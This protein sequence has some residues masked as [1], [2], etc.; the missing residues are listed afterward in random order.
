MLTCKFFIT[1]WRKYKM[2]LNFSLD[3]L[4]LYLDDDI[5]L[6]AD[7]LINAQKLVSLTQVEKN[8]FIARF[9]EGGDAIETEV[10]FAGTKVKIAT[11][12]CAEFHEKEICRHIGAAL[13]TLLERRKARGEA[14]KAT[15]Q[16][17]AQNAEAPK[18]T[19]PNILK[20]IDAPQLIEFIAD[21]ARNDK[22]FALA[23]KTRF[24][25]DLSSGTVE[26]HYKT[27]IDNTLRS[28]KNPKGRITPKGWQQVFTMID[29]LR[30]K[31]E[32]LLKSGELSHCFDVI[33]VTLPLVH[34]LMRTS[35]SPK[36]KIERRQVLLTEILRGFD[37]LLVSPELGQQMWNFI[38]TEYAQNSR[39]E[40][41]TRLFDALLKKADT[42]NR[43]ESLLQTIDTQIIACR[44][45]LD[46]KDRLMTQKVQVLQKSGRVAEASALILSVSANPDVLL[47][48]VENALSNH[49]YQLA[50]SLCENGLHIFKKNQIAREVLEENLLTIAEN[51]S[52]TEG[53]YFYG[54]RRLLATFRY[55]FYERLKKNNLT[56]K[57]KL[58]LIQ[59]L[60]NQ[61]YRIE[62]RDLL[63]AIYLEERQ[64]DK[65]T[66][67]ISELQSLE[68]L[69]RYGVDLYKID[70]ESTVELHKKVFYEYLYTHLGRPPAQ[71]IRQVLES[72]IARGGRTLAERLK[73]DIKKDFPERYSLNEE[74][75]DMMEDL[76]RK[77][78]LEQ[79]GSTKYGF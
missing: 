9:T 12:E 19:I 48:A 27:L 79:K 35:E 49:D 76:E 34:R 4:E 42:E 50:K 30:Q 64:L 59:K 70:A 45:F 24:A 26:E 2:K 43:V 28:V 18:L 74:L 3:K 11:C 6:A 31:A 60:E 75:E 7:N 69:R 46:I 71:R 65:L 78:I 47:F 53:V 39:Q 62:K 23:L 77:A 54:E 36:A 25:S 10:Q 41:S 13:L 57:K 14:R 5:L 58:D 33:K 63:A 67:M 55:D 29:E 15:A 72:L 16:K 66:S 22:Q 68:L 38:L 1:V 56:P 8:L 17:A 21:Y 44:Q 32:T 20:R 37:E 61:T 40:F 51:T 73:A 52:D